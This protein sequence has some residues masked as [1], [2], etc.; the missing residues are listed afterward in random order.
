MKIFT[1]LSG[2]VIMACM[3]V[4][5]GLLL[6]TSASAT[7]PGD[8]VSVSGQY[9]VTGFTGSLDPAYNPCTSLTPSSVGWWVFANDT[10]VGSGTDSSPGCSF[11]QSP[12]GANPGSYRYDFTYTYSESYTYQIPSS[13]STPSTIHLALSAGSVGNV[14]GTT[15]VQV[16]GA[17]TTTYTTAPPNTSTDSGIPTLPATTTTAPSAPAVTTTPTN[18]T[19]A[20]TGP[21]QSTIV[22]PGDTVTEQVT[23]SIITPAA[24]VIKYVLSVPSV[25]TVTQSN[26]AVIVVIT[27]NSRSLQ[28]L[29]F[30]TPKTKRTCNTGH[31]T[32]RVKI[33]KAKKNQVVKSV[34]TLLTNGKVV[35]SKTVLIKVRKRA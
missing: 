9:Q 24:P 22:V 33:A 19:P 27:T 14:I 35:A 6:V 16:E 18:T 21:G 12:D 8:T 3:G 29:C 26:F 1:K 7:Q 30:A 10:Q 11:T 13:T 25:V 17:P 4:V 15:D 31:G 20:I 28:T 32:W 34:F 5:I 23:T 2:L